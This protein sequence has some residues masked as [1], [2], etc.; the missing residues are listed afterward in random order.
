MNEISVQLKNSKDV[1]V[2]ASICCVIGLIIGLS[3]QWE[4]WIW[5]LVGIL[6]MISHCFRKRAPVAFFN[7]EGFGQGK[8]QFTWREIEHLEASADFVSIK[9][10]R[11]KFSILLPWLCDENVLHEMGALTERHNIPIKLRVKMSQPSGIGAKAVAGHVVSGMY[12]LYFLFLCVGIFFFDFSDDLFWFIL[13]LGLILFTIMIVFVAVTV[14]KRFHETLNPEAYRT[15][16]CIHLIS[17]VFFGIALTVRSIYE[18]AEINAGIRGFATMLW[19]S[20]FLILNFVSIV[21]ISK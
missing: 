7:A 19:L 17:F 10:R 1:L 11:R 5:T 9:L 21:K 16:N 12:S 2:A 4:G 13:G 6:L 3:G 20:P 14:S 18:P 15:L 8:N